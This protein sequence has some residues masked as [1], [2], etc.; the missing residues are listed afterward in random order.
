MSEQKKKVLLT[1]GHGFMGKA[2]AELFFKEGWDVFIVDDGSSPAIGSM[3]TDYTYYPYSVTD[4]R[5]EE[6]FRVHN[7]DLV[8]HNAERSTSFRKDNYLENNEINFLGLVNMLHLSTDYNVK[9]FYLVSTGSV[10]SANH[11]EADEE[12]ESTVVN[13]RTLQK[14]TNESYAL[15]WRKVF[16]LDVTVLRFSTIYGPGQLP[17]HGVV[18]EFMQDMLEGNEYHLA[19]PDTQTRDFLYVN[20]AAFAV[21]CAAQRGYRGIRLN[22]SSGEAVSFKDFVDTCKKVMPNVRYRQEDGKTSVFQRAILD[23]TRCKKKLGWDVK[24]SLLEGLTKTYNWYKDWN[25]NEKKR[26][27]KELRERKYKTMIEKVRPYAENI[28]FFLVMV[29]LM[30]QQKGS[31]VNTEIGL[32]FNYVYI[33]IMGLLYGKKQSIPAVVLSTALLLYTFLHNGADLVALLYLPQHLLHFASYLFVGVLTGYITDNKNRLVAEETYQKEK[34]VER[35]NFLENMYTENVDVKNKLYHQIVNSDDSIGRIYR[36]I[37][38]LDSVEIENVFTK[39][40]EVTAEVLNVEHVVLYVV[41]ADGKYL[42]Q[43][44]RYGEQLKNGMHSLKLSDM[45]Y[46]AKVFTEKTV[47][48][49]RELE[50]GLPDLAAPIVYQDKVI[51]IVGI[52]DMKFDQWSLYQQNMLSMTTRLIAAA[53]GKAYQYE[54]SIQSQKYLGTTRILRDTEFDKICAEILQRNQIQ[55]ADLEKNILR[56]STPIDDYETLDEVLSKS[57]RTEDF[58]GVKNGQ[59]CILL[60]DATD[61]AVKVI[62][63]RLMQQGISTIDAGERK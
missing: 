57:I 50:K 16:H 10:V 22:I 54:E 19:G 1:G 6:I 51:A 30:L 43:K 58:I 36:V 55:P 28:A 61:G 11:Q 48:V 38:K 49:N 26:Q 23:N 44:V 56:I 53:M 33:A 3:S 41:S 29:V 45:P 5:C 60:I 14:S 24:F 20:D 4:Q 21:Y 13:L 40:A 52:F 27:E 37:R 15:Y 63:D 62:R 42:R 35:Y 12:E 31:I 32:D 8:I 2:M 9:Q 7:I 39:A 59:V 25:L 47:F 34:A 17:S 18:A 46:L